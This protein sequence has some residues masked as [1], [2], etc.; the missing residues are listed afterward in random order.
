MTNHTRT[1]PLGAATVTIINV[2]DLLLSLSE[3]MNVPERQW[4]PHYAAAF[5]HLN[6]LVDDG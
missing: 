1:I 2:G 3:V 6:V 5:E 4:R